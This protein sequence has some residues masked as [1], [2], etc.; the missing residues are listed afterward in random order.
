MNPG[1]EYADKYIMGCLLAK[2]AR[3]RPSGGVGGLEKNGRTGSDSALTARN[4]KAKASIRRKLVTCATHIGTSVAAKRRRILGADEEGMLLIPTS[5]RQ[6]RRRRFAATLRAD[7]FCGRY[8]CCEPSSMQKHRLP[9]PAA[10]SPAKPIGAGPN[11]GGS[12]GH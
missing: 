2:E 8:L 1:Y 3:F 6:R 9:S 5:R 7:G 4:G 11:M 12:T 10:I